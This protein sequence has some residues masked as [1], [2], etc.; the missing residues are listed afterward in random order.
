MET[1][2]DRVLLIT[3]ASSGI[4]GADRAL[5]V[6]CDVRD[7]GSVD[8]AVQR[9]LDRFGRLDAVFANAGIG[10]DS[11]GFSGG[12]PDRWRAPYCTR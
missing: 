4:G 9:A 11:G 3:G 10:G 5:P 8:A 6:G 1:D 2:V 7:Y 12:D